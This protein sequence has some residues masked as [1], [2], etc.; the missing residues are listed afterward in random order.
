[1]NQLD[2]DISN[3]GIQDLES[4]FRLDTLVLYEASDVELKENE[5]RTLLLSTGHIEKHVKRDLINF[6]EE[7]KKILINNIPSAAPTTITK[8]KHIDQTPNYPVYLP[9]P[10]RE[11]NIIYQNPKPVIYTQESSFVPGSRNPIDRRTLNRCLSIDTRFRSNPYKTTSSDFI[12]TIPNK[13]QKVVSIQCNSFEI[14][15]RGIPNVSSSLGNNFL[16]VS[17]QTI[18]EKDYSNVFLLPT[19]HYNKTLLIE[20][21][22]HLFSEQ[23]HTPFLFLYMVMDPLNSGKIIFTIDDKQPE[24]SNQIKSVTLDFTLNEKGEPDKTQDYVSKMGRMLGFTKRKYHG[25]IQYISETIMNP[26]LCVPYFYLSL[27]DFQNRSSHSFEPAYNNITTPQSLLARIIPE[28][29]KEEESNILQPCRIISLPRKYFGPVDLNR[30]HVKL[31]DSYGQTIDMN[32]NDYSFCLM[33]E[34]IYE[35]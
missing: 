28:Q 34:T 4:F 6:L 23:K 32:H 1:M 25:K 16:Y 15:S 24:Y 5:I 7:A 22:N 20:T 11:E 2:L 30:F 29:L 3:Y 19:G 27:E 12:V 14:V 35:N 26:Y 18:E 21:F 33:I 10:T 9:P 8:Q 13:I 17:I 31:L